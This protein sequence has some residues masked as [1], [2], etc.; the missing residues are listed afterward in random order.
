MIKYVESDKVYP[1]LLL[2]YV[3]FEWKHCLINFFNPS[4]KGRFIGNFDVSAF[5]SV[6]CRLNEWKRFGLFLFDSCRG[7]AGS[8]LQFIKA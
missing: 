3:T 7:R 8:Q 6:A 2:D 5:L 1:M 4:L